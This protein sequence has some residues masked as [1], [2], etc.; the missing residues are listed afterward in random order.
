M[1]IA[2]P[3]VFTNLQLYNSAADQGNTSTIKILMG[4][5]AIYD[6]FIEGIVIDWNAL[7]GL[8]TGEFLAF[9]VS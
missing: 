3:P 7:I 6:T 1:I 4:R 8:L 2:F 9:D 5:R